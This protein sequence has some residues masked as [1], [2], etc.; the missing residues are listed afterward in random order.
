MFRWFKKT[1][2]QGAASVIKNAVN[3]MIK[4]IS[5]IAI[6]LSLG[7]IVLLYLGPEINLSTGIVFR[8]AVPSIVLAIST[9][10]VYELWVTNGRRSAYEESEYQELL[11]LYSTKSENLNYPTAQEFLDAELERRYNVEH[12]RLTRR[13]NREIELLNKLERERPPGSRK[14]SIRDYMDFFMTKVNIKR[15]TRELGS[16]R[17][18]MPYE[19]SEEFDYLRYNLQDL[20]YKEYSPNDTRKHLAGLR[21]KKYLSIFTFTIIGLNALSIGGSFGDIWVAII[22]SSLA[23]ITLLS[24]V[25]TGFSNGYHNIKVVSTGVYKTANS[26]LDQAV[27][28]CK[29][30]GKDL[31]YRG[32]TE[33]RVSVSPV[34]NT[35]PVV[36]TVEREADIFTKAALEVTR[37]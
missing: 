10:I 19:K 8:L 31:Y 12:D 15:L 28:Y 22:M 14:K 4:Y 2:E 29:R 17:I 21:I 37:S 16:I 25:I 7:I 20:I 3:S 6:F 27:A 34:V 23:F 11:T 33:F 5:I 24:A 9:T 1:K 18:S 13:L 36:V 26:F 32:N 30:T 35:Q